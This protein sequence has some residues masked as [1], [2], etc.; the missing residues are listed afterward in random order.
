VDWNSAGSNAVPNPN[1]QTWFKT[2]RLSSDTAAPKAELASI[3]FCQFVDSEAV[4][5][6]VAA[7][8]NARMR[9]WLRAEESCYSSCLCRIGNTA[10]YAY[11]SL[12]F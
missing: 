6:R 3:L 10:E 7:C 4:A 11:F 5:A 8:D 12:M 9:I 1:L 2:V